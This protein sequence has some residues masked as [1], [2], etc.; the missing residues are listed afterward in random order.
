[1]NF[2]FFSIS[3]STRVLS[4]AKEFAMK[5]SFNVEYKHGPIPEGL[6]N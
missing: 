4:L 5:H 3:C 6:L 2:L 1:M